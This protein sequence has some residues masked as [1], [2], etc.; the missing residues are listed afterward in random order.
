MSNG[1]KEEQQT[2]HPVTVEKAGAAPVALA[3]LI[4]RCK[5]LMDFG[6]AAIAEH[7]TLIKFCLYLVKPPCFGVGNGEILFVGVEM[8]K[9]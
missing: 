5:S 9:C 6:M 4:Q 1:R 8:V 2:R 7:N 3:N